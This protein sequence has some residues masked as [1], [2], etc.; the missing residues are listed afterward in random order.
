MK[1]VD[2]VELHLIKNETFKMN[3]IV[4]RFSGNFSQKTVARRVLVAQI[5]ATANAKYPTAQHFRKR[6]AHLYGA[7]LSTKVSTKG[8]VHIV[9]IEIVFLKNQ[10]VTSTENLLEDIIDF[11]YQCL[12]SPLIT[13]EQYQSSFFNNEQTN[14]MNYLHAD[15][16]DGFYSSYLELKKLFYENSTLQLSKYGTAELVSNENSY[17]V[18]QEFQKMLRE[19]YIDIFL[20]G[21]FDEYRMIQLFNRFPF[22]NRY[23]ELLFYYQNSTNNMI[24]Q[25]VQIDSVSQSILQLG[26]RFSTH[27]QDNSYCA[28]LVFNGLFGGFSHSRLFTELREKEGLSYTIGSQFDVYTGL[29]NI[30]TGI[31]KKDRNKTFQLINK[32][33]LDI[34]TGRFS[35]SLIRQ[36]RKMLS[37]NLKLSYDSPKA[38]IEYVYNNQHFNKVY[39]VDELVNR[40]DNVSK[41]DVLQICK[42]MTLKV[43]YFLEGED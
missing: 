13:V 2:G 15:M 27:H 16:E 43:I 34:K 23:K 11:L 41:S 18:F 38:R 12:F 35:E 40:I 14:L 9:D 8:L 21:E 10:F 39:G 22:E 24:K 29:L 36:T 26:Y 30:Y 7:T 37:N 3:H 25:K 17:T 20:L 19:D 28:L 4:F 42:D 32:Q 31:D 6:L 33:F 1:L 5:L